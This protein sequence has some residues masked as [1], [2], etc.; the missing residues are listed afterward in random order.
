MF[1]CPRTAGPGME[2][3]YSYTFNEQVKYMFQQRSLDKLSSN[4]TRQTP[5]RGQ[6]IRMFGALLFFPSIIHL[7]CHLV[8]RPSHDCMRDEKNYSVRSCP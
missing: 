4:R 1:S 8:V 5:K 7:G 2:A 3:P 6:F